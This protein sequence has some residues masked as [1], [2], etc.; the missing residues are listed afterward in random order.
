M[1]K[2]IILISK[3]TILLFSLIGILWVLYFFLNPVIKYQVTNSFYSNIIYTESSKILNNKMQLRDNLIYNETF[4]I[5]WNNQNVDAFWKYFFVDSEL[6]KNNNIKIEINKWSIR[7]NHIIA[8]KKWFIGN[9]FYM[10]EEVI[11]WF[12]KKNVLQNYNCVYFQ[13]WNLDN[14]KNQECTTFLINYPIQ[15]ENSDYIFLDINFDKDSN[16]NIELEKRN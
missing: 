3:A 7:S 12:D 2:Y 6:L 9:I 10:T 14:N 4:E 13:I 5:T 16:I 15:F 8:F 1:K 11:L